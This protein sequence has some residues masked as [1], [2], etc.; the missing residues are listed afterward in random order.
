MQDQGEYDTRYSGVPANDGAWHHI[1]ITW[2]SS[3][4]MT[5]L[6]DNGRQANPPRLGEYYASL[7]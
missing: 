7:A 2:Q 3:D 1:A 4:G 5:R 6:Y